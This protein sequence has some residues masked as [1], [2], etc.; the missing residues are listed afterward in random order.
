MIAGL[1]NDIMFFFY[2]SLSLPS[3]DNAPDYASLKRQPGRTSLPKSQ[4]DEVQSKIKTIKQPL[5]LVGE[6]WY[7]GSITRA[8]AEKLLTQDGHFLVRDSISQPGEFVLTARWTGGPLHFKVN[9]RMFA[10]PDG[11]TKVKYQFEED[12][13]D[14]VVQ[15]VKNY[16]QNGK[17]VSEKSGAIISIPVPR[18]KPLD[19]QSDRR[20]S[21]RSSRLYAARSQP[22]ILKMNPE[23]APTGSPE[24]SPL[25][26][27]KPQRAGSQPLLNFDND[28]SSDNEKPT[29]ERRESMPLTTGTFSIPQNQLQ[30]IDGG[31]YSEL[32]IKTA[33]EKENHQP[34]VPLMKKS[35][36]NN[37]D[38]L[39]KST[40]SPPVNSGT[41]QEADTSKR[42]L[43][44]VSS[45]P[46]K[47]ALKNS[48]SPS[49]KLPIK[50]PP[51]PSRVPSVKLLK[52][53]KK[54]YIAVR[55]TELYEDDGSD[56]S[57][58]FQVKDWGS[59]GFAN[60]GRKRTE[61]DD[62]YA[63]LPT[64]DTQ[65]TADI[66]NTQCHITSPDK[67]DS[68][69][70]PRAPE[71]SVQ[72]RDDLVSLP[73]ETMPS[74]IDLENY[75]SELLPPNNKPMDNTAV[76]TIKMLLLESNPRHLA[77]HITWIDLDMLMVPQGQDIGLRVTSGLEMI[78][79]PQGKQL[80]QDVLERYN[81][82]DL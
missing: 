24:H 17:H 29:L 39:A 72:C 31:T 68:Y 76:T 79:L 38:P 3:R 13:F 45:A 78:A 21:L 18:T 66:L 20:D 51:K 33:N 10:L 23:L 25:S 82:I 11:T 14:D 8:K 36:K 4:R 65:R 54:P 57:D 40:S 67:K 80:R 50:P 32:T 60:G 35:A 34:S 47:S 37:K 49:A 26:R 53:Q 42:P 81:H 58:Y 73:L 28:G 22:N 30:D 27:R 59:A 1:K 12:A 74:F 15:L 46:L 56:Y 7:H 16:V 63:E 69:D 61:D 62:S 41:G 6:P 64:A 55:N 19:H 70:V 9:S 71:E 43:E 77:Q 48:P 52:Q 2:F 44:K 5:V 75:S